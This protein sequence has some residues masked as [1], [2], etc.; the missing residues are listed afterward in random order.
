MVLTLVVIPLNRMLSISIKEASTKM[1]DHKDG[2]IR[3]TGEM[4]RGMRAVKMLAWEQVGRV[5]GIQP[6]I[7]FG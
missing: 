5:Q 3:L 1:M 7:C 4:L 2:R 6:R